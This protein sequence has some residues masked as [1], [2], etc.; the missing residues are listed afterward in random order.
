MDI[1]ELKFLLKLLGCRNYRTALTA[2]GFKDLKNKNKICKSLNDREIIDYSREIASVKILP[3]GRAVLKVDPD[4]LPIAAK[5][6]QVLEKISKFT[7][8]IK[9]SQIKAVEV[10]AEEKEVILRSLSDRGLIELESQMKR[11]KAE[12][13][14]TQRGLNY[15]RDEYNPKGNTTISL[16]LLNNYL[17]FLRKSLRGEI[18]PQTE[19]KPTTTGKLS[20]KQILQ[21][22]KDLD[23]EQGTENYLPIFHLRQRLQPQLSREE[24]DRVLYRLQRTDAIELS[25]LVDPTPYT[26]E[27]IDAGIPKDVGGALFFIIVN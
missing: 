6:L 24:L 1:N 3:P 8:K 20:D 16:E 25:T 18:Q 15:L 2:R 22:I 13:W 27:Q 19:T 14:I 23:R 21:I 17:R 4:K 10:K 9:P 26:S 7:A 12:A 11:T 5:E